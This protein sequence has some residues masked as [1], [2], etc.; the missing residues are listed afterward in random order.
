MIKAL[1]LCLAFLVGPVGAA[2]WERIEKLPDAVADSEVVLQYTDGSLK[3]LPKHLELSGGKLTVETF[4]DFLARWELDNGQLPK[5]LTWVKKDNQYI[6]VWVLPPAKE[7]LYIQ[8]SHLLSKRQGRGSLSRFTEIAGGARVFG[9]DDIGTAIRSMFI[10]ELTSDV[11]TKYREAVVFPQEFPELLATCKRSS[12]AARL[13]WLRDS[14]LG[15]FL[16]NDDP[17]RLFLPSQCRNYKPKCLQDQSAQCVRWRA[18][19]ARDDVVTC[20]HIARGCVAC[21]KFVG[22]LSSAYYGQTQ[23]MCEYNVNRYCNDFP[24]KCDEIVQKICKQY[25]D[26]CGR[27]AG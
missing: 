21:E 5:L 8:F 20:I 25:P 18:D 7:P 17:P 19:C 3:S 13:Q 12:D 14:K 11:D 4:V 22:C 23:S 10:R 26:V 1:V 9:S 2:E 6:G 15:S 16:L 24:N 27:R